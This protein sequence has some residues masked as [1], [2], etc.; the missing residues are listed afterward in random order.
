MVYI[1]STWNP[2]RCKKALLYKINDFRDYGW[3]YAGDYEEDISFKKAEEEDAWG[4]SVE[5][6]LG[7][8]Y[9]GVDGVENSFVISSVCVSSRSAGASC[10]V[11][12]GCENLTKTTGLIKIELKNQANIFIKKMA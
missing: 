10:L 8:A 11:R 2:Q 3:D 6:V 9:E 12:G 1:S 7:A 5:G 4:G